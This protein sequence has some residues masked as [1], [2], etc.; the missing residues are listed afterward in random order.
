VEV[1]LGEKISQ[2]LARRQ[3]RPRL[4]RQAHKLLGPIEGIVSGKASQD[5]MAMLGILR[6]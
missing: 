1:D 4:G 6:R 3:G 5:E 2:R